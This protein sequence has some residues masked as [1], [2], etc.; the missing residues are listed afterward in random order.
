[1]GIGAFPT[2]HEYYTGM[3]GM[4][5]SEA[6]NIGVT[7]CDL[8]IVIGARFSDRVIGKADQFAPHA[9]ILHIDIDPAEVNKNIRS[10]H[11]IIGD[12]K[13]V[14]ERLNKKLTQLDHGKW[15]KEILGLKTEGIKKMPDDRLRAKE[16]IET[17]DELT[18]N[19]DTII[20]TDVGQ[21]Q[22]WAAQYYH[23]T[24]PRQFL[25]SGGLGTMGYGLGAAMGAKVGCPEKRVVNIAGDGCFRMN[26]I[27]LATCVEYHIP[28]MIVIMNN[29]VLGMVRQWQT[30]FFGKR[31]SQT[32]IDR[33]TDFIKLTESYG[34]AAF[35]LGW[36]DD[37]K[38]VL[39]KA[40]A[41]DGP[42][43]VN[44]DINKDDKVFPMV[45][46]GTPISDV[47]IGE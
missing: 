2:D 35:S 28:I 47:I 36:D 17:L 16:I 20:A 43:V 41:V 39:E 18:K 27:E 14:L 3:I 40:L 13:E 21:H 34:A 22:M 12:I 5:G 4:H 11:F 9:Q 15:M 37:V 44:C 42:V 30:L 1:M 26:C 45:A 19:E 10:H 7:E 38:T 46:P 6:S 23:F 33:V 24:K 32:T 8:L 25:T 29:R 31:Y